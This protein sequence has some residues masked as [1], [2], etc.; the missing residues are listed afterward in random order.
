[1]NDRPCGGRVAAAAAAAAPF[2][3]KERGAA[4]HNRVTGAIRGMLNRR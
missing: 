2:P 3:S 4:D 1:V